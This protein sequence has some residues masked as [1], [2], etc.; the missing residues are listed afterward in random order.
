MSQNFRTSLLVL[1][2]A[3]A[4]LTIASSANADAP[5]QLYGKTVMLRWQE[6]R[7]QRDD[8]GKTIKVNTSSSVMVYVSDAGRLF[9]SMSRRNELGSNSN[10]VDPQGDN[11]RSGAGASSSLVPSFEG[12]RL[13][14]NSAMRSGARQIEA[15]FNPSFSNCSL[16]VRFGRDGDAQI[17]HRAMDGRM[18]NIV[19][20]SVSG[21]SCAIRSGNALPRS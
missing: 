8:S 3:S 1:L 17:R 5:S 16:T 13:L 9:T 14:L 12:S 4:G 2:C 15:A 11:Q 18:Y 7:V 20:T 21:T 6:V 19:S 10:S